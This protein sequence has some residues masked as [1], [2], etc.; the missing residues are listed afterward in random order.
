MATQ[1][2]RDIDRGWAWWVLFASYLNLLLCSGLSYVA[3][4]FQVVFLQEFHGSVALTSWVTSL[5]SS[6]MQLGG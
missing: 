3:G 4:M 1:P 5:F 2:H 6:F